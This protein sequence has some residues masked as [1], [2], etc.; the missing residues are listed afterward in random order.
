MSVDTNQKQKD[1]ETLDYISRQIDEIMLTE[2]QQDADFYKFL[3]KQQRT[4]NN[5]RRDQ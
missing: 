4:L 2:K 1:E 5:Y 3:R